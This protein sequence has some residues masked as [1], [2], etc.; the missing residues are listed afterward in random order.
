MFDKYR[1]VMFPYVIRSA[2]DERSRTQDILEEAF[3][4]GPIIIKTAQG[5]D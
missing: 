4:Q 3:L 2:V 1:D 5:D